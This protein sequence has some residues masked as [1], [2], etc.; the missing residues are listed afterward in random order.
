MPPLESNGGI[1][2]AFYLALLYPLVHPFIVKQIWHTTI[3]W[4]E[5]VLNSLLPIIAVAVLWQLGTYSQTHDVEIWS[6]KVTEKYQDSVACDHSYSCNCDS[7]D[8]NCSTC[9]D[10]FFDYDW[11]VK[12]TA[13]NFLIDRIDRQGRDMPSRWQQVQIGEPTAIEHA[14][15]NY[16]KA[17]PD[18]LFNKSSASSPQFDD[19]IPEYPRT[20]DYRRVV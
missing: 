5:M 20:Y 17:V 3:N 6:G 1:M 18:S 19:L 7:K 15:V 2:T 12:S 4:Q 8:N 16:I 11:V 9:Y 14:F 10:H 13:G